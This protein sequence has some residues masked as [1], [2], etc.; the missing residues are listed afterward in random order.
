M[1][2]KAM[3]INSK[4]SPHQNLLSPYN[5]AEMAP[6]KCK[7]P[8]TIPPVRKSRKQQNKFT[9]GIFNSMNL[10]WNFLLNSLYFSIFRCAFS[11]ELFENLLNQIRNVCDMPERK[12][13]DKITNWFSLDSIRVTRITYAFFL[14]EFST[15]LFE[16]FSEF[17]FR[18]KGFSSTNGGKKNLINFLYKI[19]KKYD[20]QVFFT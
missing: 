2:F 5:I 6:R 10:S 16:I 20:I 7:T 14:V 13:C 4:Y 9:V 8:I 12:S 19:N 11:R 15:V 3:R 17:L 18:W 1:C